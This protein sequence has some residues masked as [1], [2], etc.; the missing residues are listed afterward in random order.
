FDEE[1][2]QNPPSQKGLVRKE[3]A[4]LFMQKI[5]EN[6]I[7]GLIARAPD[8]FGPKS[9]NSVLYPSFLQQMLKGK[10]PMTLS[11][12]HQPHTFSYTPDI[13]TTMIELASNEDCYGQIWH[14]PVLPAKTL[15]EYASQFNKE[16]HTNLKLSRMPRAMM[17]LLKW[18]VP[19]LKE[20]EEMN[21]QFE[22]PYHMNDEKFKKRFPSFPVTSW[23]KAVA[24]FVKSFTNG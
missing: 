12:M 10:N 19:I 14:T 2:G 11:N 15:E 7:Q 24:E 5:E 13:A 20:V 17:Q 22:H 4:G 23:E 18:F 8:F 1:T 21:Y 16:L 6:K 9:Y 3:V